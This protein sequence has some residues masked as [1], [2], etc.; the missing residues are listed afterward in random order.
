MKK[1]YIL[2]FIIMLLITTACGKDNQEL[3]K[4]VSKITLTGDLVTKKIYYHNVAEYDGSKSSFFLRVFGIDKKAWIE[5]TGLTDLSIDLTEVKITTNGNKI[6]VFIPKTKINKVYVKNDD[7]S[8]IVFY[9][10]KGDIFNL[11]N[12]SSAEGVEALK[13]AQEEMTEDVKANTQLLR[14][15]QI[16]AKNLIEE[17]IKVFTEESGLSYT[18]E[19]EY[20]ENIY[21]K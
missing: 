11:G 14:M 13:V 7:P 1:R 5:Y 10:S 4:T 9:N 19:W 6:H 12:V 18:I 17:K 2:I 15:A 8:D 3:E 21:E 20:E 16:R